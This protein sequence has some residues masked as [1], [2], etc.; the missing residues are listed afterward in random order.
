M[1]SQEIIIVAGPN[2][3]GK[4]TFAM[5]YLPVHPDGMDYINADLIAVGLAPM[6]PL[7]ANIRAGR[8]LLA[9]LDRLTA[10]KQS[11]A[12]E[13]TLSGRA[14]L[15]RIIRW[16]ELGYRVTLLFLS[17]PSA[18]EAVERVRHRVAKGGHHVPED[19]VR[20]RFAAG[21]SN[22]HNVYAEAVAEWVLFDNR[23]RTPVIL[24]Q[25]GTDGHQW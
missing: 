15:R 1:A 8:L 9:E 11:F 24:D 16:R 5:K 18:D 19:D 21:L 20:R 3:A 4:T 6:D 22:F 25:K 10:E 7:S 13:T 23:S 17:L 12:F 2:G 14:Y